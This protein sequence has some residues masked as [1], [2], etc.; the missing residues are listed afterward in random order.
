M[1]RV[2]RCRNPGVVPV[3][4]ETP[5]R[6]RSNWLSLPH[7]SLRWPAFTSRC[8]VHRTPVAEDVA[9]G[10]L[11]VRAVAGRLF[12]RRSGRQRGMTLVELLVAV[13]VVG[14]L[15]SISL[16]AVRV[17]RWC[18]AFTSTCSAGTVAT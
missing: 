10:P 17:R 11:P 12:Y 9:R 5:R 13:S 18:P 6:S 16:P 14:V 1:Q 3:L 15:V 2:A 7:S 4:N 8:R